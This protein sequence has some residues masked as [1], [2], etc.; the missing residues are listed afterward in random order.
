L[1][2]NRKLFLTAC[3]TFLLSLAVSSTESADKMPAEKAGIIS[4]P[5]GK[6]AFL[7]DKSVWT[8]D[9][10][11]FL[12]GK[13]G[14]FEMI[15]EVSN[16]DG[17]LSWSPDNKLILFTRS[18]T[19]DLRGPDGLGGKH[20]VYDIYTAFIDSAYANRRN[21]WMG[22]TSSLGGR[23]PEW[24]AASNRVTFWQDMNAD[25]ANALFPNYQIC[26]MN[27]D[28]SDIELIRKDWQNFDSSTGYMMAPSMGNDGSL[29][30][31]M[32]FDMRPQ[33]I[34]V[35]A[36]NEYMISVDSLK[37][38]A[39]KNLRKVAPCWSP[40]GKWI[41][42]VLN[43]L[44]NPGVYVAT[45]DFKENYLVFVPPVGTSLFTLSPSFSPDSKWLT[46]STTDGSIWMSD[47]T[48]NG[49]RRLSGPGLDAY[50]AW[51]K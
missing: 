24:S 44:N 16:A 30:F 27:P 50:P 14:A 4:A 25:Q 21:F 2:L 45:P 29:A 42:Y 41:A 31:T 9:I 28:G 12:Q 20:K 46:F 1:K 15:S 51:S 11:Q 19:V 38:R 23:D 35:L 7:R 40:D 47:I 43:D 17:R 5:S 32:L 3:A 18:G 36:K 34:V 48:G 10:N 26:T 6:I 22:V 8:L 49:Q 13:T 39:R 37:A 33:G